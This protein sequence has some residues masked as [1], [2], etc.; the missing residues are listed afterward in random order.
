MVEQ[1]VYLIEGVVGPCTVS[2]PFLMVAVNRG[3]TDG[4]ANDVTPQ[5]P[6][7]EG[8]MQYVNQNWPIQ[9]QRYPSTAAQII[10]DP[11]KGREKEAKLIL[12]LKFL[13]TYV[14]QA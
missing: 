13:R 11:Q 7:T 6:G 3:R 5:K 1:I 12:E 10:R 8:E 4:F 14:L 9:L 2:L